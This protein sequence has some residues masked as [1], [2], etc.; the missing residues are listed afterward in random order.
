MGQDRETVVRLAAEFLI[1][2]YGEDA[3]RVARNNADSADAIRDLLTADAWR[4]IAHAV[5]ALQAP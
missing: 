2:R 5:D 3:A 4:D 1:A